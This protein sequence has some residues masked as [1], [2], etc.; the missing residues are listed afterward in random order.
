[1]NYSTKKELVR[2]IV[3]EADYDLGK[4]LYVETAEEPELV[5]SF[6]QSLVDVV[7]IHLEDEIEDLKFLKALLA[8]GVDNWEGYEMAQE[9]LNE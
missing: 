5:D 7:D 8:A 9:F 1:M 4:Q 2:A 3:N 6:I